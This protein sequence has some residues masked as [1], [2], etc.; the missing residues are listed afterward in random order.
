MNWQWIGDQAGLASAL[1]ISGDAVGV[2]T[3]FVRE[4]T[5]WPIPG[6]I[7]IGNADQVFLVDPLAQMDFSGLG[8]WMANPDQT[9]IMHAGFEDLELFGHH[10]DCLP[11]PYFDTQLAEACLGGPISLGL[12]ALVQS[13]GFPAMDKTKSRNDWTVR[14]LARDLLDYAAQ[15][16]V[17]LPEIADR[18]RQ[19]LIE[20]DRLGWLIE[21]QNT[22]I[23]RVRRHMA[24]DIDPMDRVKGLHHLDGR[25]MTLMT[26]MV[27]WREQLARES[28]TA[29]SRIARDEFL[30]ALA[31]RHTWPGNL[32]GLEGARSSSIRQYA[33]SLR[34]VYED[35]QGLPVMDPL[36]QPKRPSAEQR[37]AQKALKADI[38][39]I[40]EREGLTPEFVAKRRDIERWADG[41]RGPTGWRAELL[42]EIL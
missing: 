19:R 21:E 13:H 41:R 8:A 39:R 31:S 5:F 14:P 11:S 28:N 42:E 16:V 33:D 17:H 27:H 34:Q 30:L 6:L 12:D 7:Q 32:G 29:R 36:A 10:F 1:Q 38:G 24:G 20:L 3:E 2:D 26:A 37:A 4:S 9:K 40:A 15:D 23:D 25:G 22:A 18:Q 35:A